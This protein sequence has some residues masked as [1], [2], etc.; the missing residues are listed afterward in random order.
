MSYEYKAIQP[1]KAVVYGFYCIRMYQLRRKGRYDVK[2]TTIL[3]LKAFVITP[4]LKASIGTS[5]LFTFLGLFY[6]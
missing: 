2:C 5:A 3:I 1:Y 4:W 6:N